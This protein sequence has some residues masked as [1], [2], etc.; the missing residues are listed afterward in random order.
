MKGMNEGS[1]S[2]TSNEK[3]A[4]IYDEYDKLFYEEN[5][6]ILHKLEFDYAMKYMLRRQYMEE[7]RSFM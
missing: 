7:E 4:K 5:F 1:K 6:R 3:A 2:L